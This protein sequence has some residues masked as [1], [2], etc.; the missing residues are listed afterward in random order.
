MCASV[1]DVAEEV[2]AEGVLGGEDSGEGDAD[3]AGAGA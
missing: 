1:D 2:A 3:D